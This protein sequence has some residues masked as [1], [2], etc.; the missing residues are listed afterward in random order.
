MKQ[1]MGRIM[2][3][4]LLLAFGGT[5]RLMA[6]EGDAELEKFIEEV[7]KTDN[8]NNGWL[9]GAELVEAANRY[10]QIVLT[11]LFETLRQYGDQDGDGR[12]SAEERKAVLKKDRQ[13]D[14][15]FRRALA[16]YDGDRDG[17]LN[18]LESVN[19]RN[20]SNGSYYDY[21]D[22]REAIRRLF[23][24]RSNGTEIPDTICKEADRDNNGFLDSAESAAAGILV[25]QQYDADGDGNLAA[26]ER[27]NC[28]EEA[29]FQD[30][31]YRLCPETDQDNDS[32]LS[33][34]EMA[35]ALALVMP[36]YD[37][38]KNGSLDS[39]ERAMVIRDGQ[40]AWPRQVLLERVMRDLGS[41]GSF[42]ASSQ[43]DRE[44]MIL[45]AATAKFG[46]AGATRFGLPEIFAWRRQ[47]E[48]M[49]M[50]S[51]Q[52]LVLDWLRSRL[53][54]QMNPAWGGD[55]RAALWRKRFALYDTNKDG[56][57]D[58]IECCRFL[59]RELSPGSANIN[60]YSSSSETPTWYSAAQVLVGGS[61]AFDNSGSDDRQALLPLLFMKVD[62]DGD[63]IFS[64]ADALALKPRM[65]EKRRETVA[66]EAI[67]AAIRAERI[68]G[69][70]MEVMPAV[71]D[72][73][74]SKYKQKFDI[75]HDGKFSPAELRTLLAE[76]EA[77]T[78]ERVMATWMDKLGRFADAD[79]DNQLNAKEKL[80]ATALLRFCYDRNGSGTFEKS[81]ISQ[82]QSDL[83][84]QTY[85]DRERQQRMVQ[86][87]ELL[88]RYDLDGDGKIS[89]TERARAEADRRRLQESGVTAPPQDE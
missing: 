89:P 7:L 41:S 27:Q 42:S 57:F 82:M 74:M 83:Q 78:R 76:T 12:I 68:P 23:S 18:R 66:R 53:E 56:K 9:D 19:C 20:M 17:R 43:S 87:R 50:L 6:A 38:D 61:R 44:E 40:C 36:V 49:Q 1:R 16:N 60:T 30:G 80:L 29:Y 69:R 52:D 85:Y 77:K 58:G 79:G 21:S 2:V 71:Q 65:E 84:Q 45:A 15:A 63:G 62:A 72:T 46:H 4:S 31:L 34:T 22:P 35:K 86:D 11:R 3:A 33:A 64:P 67:M 55:A 48:N 13:P 88:H 73:E 59:Q 51:M 54:A 47:V 10:P 75:D 5:T 14:A 26:D 24:F 70:D 37:V 81:E 39:A 25:M 32:W 8:N 28:S